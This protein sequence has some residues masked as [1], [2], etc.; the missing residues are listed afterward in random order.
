MSEA[1]AFFE[2]MGDIRKE[3]NY[4]GRCLFIFRKAVVASADGRT[5]RAKGDRGIM[6]IS[7]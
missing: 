4:I 3:Q 2:Q 1:S 5:F 7:G 6:A